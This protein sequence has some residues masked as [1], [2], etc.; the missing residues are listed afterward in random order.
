MEISIE[1]IQE[2]EDPYYA[3]VDSVK[4]KETLR[5]YIT[6]LHRFLKLIPNSIYLEHLGQS[7]DNDSKEILSKFF[8]MLSE[9]NSKLSQNIIAAFIKEVRKKS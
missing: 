1:S 9:K 7:P 3:F 2:V 8:V 6:H 4:N 5:K